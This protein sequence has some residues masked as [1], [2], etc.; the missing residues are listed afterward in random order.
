M[1]S[2]P[3]GKV[4][5]CALAAVLLAAAW[6][7]GD[8]NDTGSSG[9]SEVSEET[10]SAPR[11]DGSSSRTAG[12]SF[13]F[14]MMHVAFDEDDQEVLDLFGRVNQAPLPPAFSVP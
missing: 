9:E 6:G 3:L 2:D 1:N 11:D 5:V 13:N 4:F 8:S 7:C 12:F 14:M 10:T